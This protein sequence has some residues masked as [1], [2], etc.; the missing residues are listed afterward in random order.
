VAPKLEDDR[1]NAAIARLQDSAGL[2]EADANKLLDWALE[3]AR[4]QALETIGG[5]GPLSTNLS[6]SRAERLAF[7]CEKA[8]RIL[9]EGEV[10]VLF[11]VTP[12]AARALITLAQATYAEALRPSL[13]KLIASN[14]ACSET[15]TDKVPTYTLNFTDDAAFRGAR[16]RA[17][18][19]NRKYVKEVRVSSSTIVVLR[20]VEFGGKKQR[21]LEFFGIS[22]CK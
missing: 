9:K 6:A 4:S 5:D 11:R 2:S 22:E 17:D 7:I 12:S 1:R 14:V 15:A 16:T 13:L 21:A 18:L 10:Q 8:Q 20:Q 3:A 19:L